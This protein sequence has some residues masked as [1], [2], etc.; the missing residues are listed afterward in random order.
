M[1]SYNAFSGRE[2]E[3]KLRAQHAR[4]RLG[5]PCH[6]TGPC[7]ICGDPDAKLEAH[8]EDYSQPYIWEPPAQY[9]LC[10]MCHS[11]LHARFHNP[12]LWEAHKAHVRR[13]G[14]SSDLMHPEIAIEFKTARRRNALS[15]LKSLR[16]RPL[17]GDEWWA[18]LST[19]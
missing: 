11:R 3:A 12:G 10:H 4:E 9:A 13:G 15:A 6:P 18:R 19:S 5:F 16:M 17:T 8:D 7:A 14:Y 1:N 2:R